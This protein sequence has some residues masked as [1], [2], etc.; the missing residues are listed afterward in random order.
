MS[1][2]EEGKGTE[3]LGKKIKIKKKGGGGILSFR[4]LYTPL[5]QHRSV[6]SSPNPELE[7]FLDT[8]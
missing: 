8:A 1:S 4:E 7:G 2:G 6:G 5:T 3:I